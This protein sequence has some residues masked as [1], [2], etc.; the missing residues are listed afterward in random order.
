[1][2]INGWGEE[3][4]KTNRLELRTLSTKYSNDLYGIWSNEEI[5][6]YTHATKVNNKSECDARVN[7]WVNEHTDKENP[8]N[9]VVLLNEKVIGIIGYPIINKEER[10]FGF[11][12]QFLKEYWGKGYASEAARAV[13]D[14]IKDIYNVYHEY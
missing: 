11:F 7:L 14:N 8:N 12:Y 13:I 3:M 9:F 4:I 1:M 2:Y 10:K 5:I 6:K